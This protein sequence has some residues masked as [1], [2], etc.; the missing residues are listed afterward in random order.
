VCYPNGSAPPPFPGEP[1]AA[2]LIR[3]AVR[4]RGGSP[5]RVAHAVPASAHRV[6]AVVLPDGRGLHGYYERFAHALAGAGIE[7]IAVDLYGR[8]AGI[9]PRDDAFPSAEHSAQLRWANVQSD[10]ATVV[11]RLRGADPQ[12]PVVTI[13][14]CLGGR[15]SLLAATV[16]ELELSG[17]I[18]LYPQTS[19]PA[20]SDLPA[21]D[22][23]IYRLGCELLC[24][25]GGADELIAS[26]EIAAWQGALADAGRTDEVVVY[27]GAPHSFFDRSAGRFA[28]ESADVAARMLAFVTGRCR[29]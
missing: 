19:G 7:T 21:P 24:V 14:F 15:I 4:P 17:A 26:T 11:G 22:Q 3:G 5:F 10:V 25:F 16:A 28:A 23:L 29:P 20:R 27:P 9:A 6:A 13:G 18:A 8:T 2:T 1:G 12:R